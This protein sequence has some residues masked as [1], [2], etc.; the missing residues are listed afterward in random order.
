[1]GNN[2]AKRMAETIAHS[3][4]VMLSGSVAGHPTH[5]VWYAGEVAG[6]DQ[7][8]GTKQNLLWYL[9]VMAS[10]LVWC[11]YQ[12]PDLVRCLDLNVRP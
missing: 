3:S 12:V 8:P 10:P 6:G 2:G 1:M 9:E 4:L 7:N 5:A 11:P